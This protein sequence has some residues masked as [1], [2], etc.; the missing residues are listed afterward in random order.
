MGHQ[1]S[2]ALDD[3]L[4]RHAMGEPLEACLA[5]YPDL[6]SQLKGLVEA[7]ER[8]N[9]LAPPPAL[10]ATSVAE[11]R[12][13]FLAA[14][15]EAKPQAVSD[16]TF[17]RLIRWILPI[18]RKEQ[19]MWIPAF[20]RVAL[21]FMIVLSVLGGTAAAAQA[22][23][24]DSPLYGVKLAIED[25]RL[26]LTSDPTQQATLALTFAT[27][28]SREIERMVVS[29]QADS[30]QVQQRLQAQLELALRNAARASQ[31]ETLRLLEQI[32]AMTQTQERVLTQAQ[33]RASTRTQETLRLALQIMAQTRQQA[34]AG[35]ADPNVF[36][37]RYRHREGEPTQPPPTPG[38]T[39]TPSPSTPPATVTAAPTHQPTRTPYPSVTPQRQQT[40]PGQ[41]PTGT[42][43][44]HAT[45]TPQQTG[46][47]PQPTPGQGDSTPR[48]T[49]GQGG[50]GSQP[51]A[52]PGGGG[53]SSGTRQP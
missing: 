44:S 9:V 30:G 17:Q 19:P 40:G 7:R 53:G 46:P 42:P 33:V 14:A 41:P 6:A 2:D 36:R 48:P 11:R 37:N 47:G 24:P 39:T 25:A 20:A 32:R 52:G 35:L 27:E 13:Q 38:S 22:S 51:T 15:R 5:R 21:V 10:S 8:L 16:G 31:S 28:R 1:L 50:P 43:G 12:R 18:R 49:P 23:G 45:V 3:I 34:E 26:S 4:A 29:N